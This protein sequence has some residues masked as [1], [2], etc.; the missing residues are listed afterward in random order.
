MTFDVQQ[1][2]PVKQN[3]K[4]QVS[5]DEL[6]TKTVKIKIIKGP[7]IKG[8]EN[9]TCYFVDKNNKKI[10]EFNSL[11][12]ELK[13]FVDKKNLNSG[14]NG[15]YTGSFVY[16][17]TIYDENNQKIEIQ[18]PTINFTYNQ[19]GRWIGTLNLSE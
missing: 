7:Y 11:D 9:V 4:R 3:W 15:N 13:L 17:K 12:H 2:K 6:K 10:T 1:N 16:D 18:T 19:N 8:Y 5:D 14:R